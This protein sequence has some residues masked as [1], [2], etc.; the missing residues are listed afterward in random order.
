MRV[1]LITRNVPA[2][3][4]IP[5]D[6]GGG[7]NTF[8]EALLEL[9]G[10]HDDLRIDVVGLYPE[11]EPMDAPP[12]VAIR[13]VRTPEQLHRWLWIHREAQNVVASFLLLAYTAV[14]LVREALRLTK[15]ERY[16][17][18]YAVGGP[19]A[20][21]AGIA[22][23]HLRGLPLAMHFQYTY[24]FSAASLPVK[25]LARWFY[26]QTDALIGNCAMLGKDAVAVGTPPER[27][28]WVFNWIDHEV[29]RPLEPREPH[30]ERYGVQP[31]QTAFYFGG[32]FDYTKHVDR[33]IDALRGLDE[34][35]AVFFFAGDGVLAPELRALSAQNPNVRVLGT[36]DRADLPALHAACDVQFWG[37][38][39]VDYPGLVA[40]EA[41]SSGLTVYTSNQTMNPLYAGERVDPSFLE[42]PR[43][44]RLYDPTREG[45]RS[46]IR[47]AIENRD[48]L[49]AARP[50]TAAFARE[51]F[52]PRNAV[53]LIEILRSCARRPRAN[54]YVRPRKERTSS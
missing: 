20:G 3:S 42:V 26:G 27:C 43:F 21:V 22:V 47:E 30:R 1:L 11:G 41:L 31:W 5:V 12:N 15:R 35:R 34:P 23:K 50:A 33:L 19:I 48:A 32:R 54:D 14:L 29:F 40:I 49:N 25:L 38:V 7:G 44:A 24:R 10:Q 16:D 13:T 6:R 17:V 45:I 46:A 53:R 52:G 9:P 18:I 39:D 37:S 28:H 2:R 36:V 51:R 4:I 8:V